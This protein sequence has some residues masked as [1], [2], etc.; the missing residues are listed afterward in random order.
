MGLRKAER[1]VRGDPERAQRLEP[2]EV[3]QRLARKGSDGRRHD[4]RSAK[5]RQNVARFRL[6]RHRFLQVN[7]R[8]SGFFKIYQ[9]IQLKILKFG[10]ILQI[11][12][13]LQIF[14]WI[15]T[16]IADFQTDFLLKF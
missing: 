4:G 6:Y 1:T 3:R 16:K 8:F 11:L 13:H 7:T 15:F 9:I 12:Q 10:N 5:F 14:C 2:R